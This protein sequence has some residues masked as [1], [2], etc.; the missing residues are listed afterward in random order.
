MT[1]MSS[2]HR[3]IVIHRLITHPEPFEPH[4]ESRPTKNIRTSTF[5]DKANKF[6]CLK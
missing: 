5:P 4:P 6:D 3:L 1:P 2:I